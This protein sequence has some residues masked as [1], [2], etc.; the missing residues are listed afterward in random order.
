MLSSVIIRHL[1][2]LSKQD[3]PSTKKTTVLY[4]YLDHKDTNV[5][6]IPNLLGS[7]LRQLVQGCTV[8]P[9]SEPVRALFKKSKGELR[10]GLKD[11]VGLINQEITTNFE[12]VYLLVDALDELPEDNQWRLRRPLEDSLPDNVRLL[13]TSRAFDDIAHDKEIICDGDECTRDPQVG[14]DYYFHCQVCDKF[15]LCKSCRDKGSS[16]PFNHE[17][18]EPEFVTKEI[19]A[20]ND[21]I[22]R[23]VKW[24][25]DQ[26]RGLGTGKIGDERLGYHG[27]IGATRLGIFCEKFPELITKI[28][29]DVS[30]KAQGMYLLAKLHMDSLKLRPSAGAVLKALTNLSTEVGKIYGDILERIDEQSKIDVSLAKKVLYWIVLARRPLEVSELLQA[31]AVDPSTTEF[32]PLEQTELTIILRVTKGLVAADGERGAVRLVHR[33]AQEYFEHHWK[34]LFPDAPTKIA[35]TILS[36][37]NVKPLSAPCNINDEEVQVGS[38]L[39]EYPFFA[40]AS[41]YWGE[42]IQAVL[43]EPE[44]Q[45]AVMKFLKDPSKLAST[46]QAAWYVG[47][48]SQSSATWNVRGGVNGLHVCAYYGLDTILTALL[49]DT[50]DLSLDSQDRELGQTPLMYACRRGHPTTVSTLIQNGADVNVRSKTGSTAVFESIQG[51]NTDVLDILLTTVPL[52]S[53][54]DVNAVNPGDYNRTVLMLAA[55]R[56][57]E[58][59]I[60]HLMQQPGILIN[61]QDTRGYTALALAASKKR[62]T[63]VERLLK[64]KEIDIDVVNENGATPLM[65][66]AEYGS[67]E[68][69]TQLLKRNPDLYLKDYDGNTAIWLAITHGRTS[70]VRSMLDHGIDIYGKNNSGRT[71]LHNACVSPDLEPEVVR[72][73]FEKGADLNARGKNGETPL[74]DASRLGNLAIAEMLI[75][76]GANHSTEDSSDRTPLIVAWQHGEID[77][78]K[79]LQ[80]HS[81]IP[82]KLPEEASLP[83]WSLAKLGYADLAQK[84]IKTKSSNLYSKDPDT[85]YTALHWSIDCDRFIILELLLDS[86]MPPNDI[87]D[88][89]RTPLHLAAELGD[90]EATE[91]LLKANPSLEVKNQ[92]SATALSVAQSNQKY[93]VATLLLEAGASIEHGHDDE[94]QPTFFA[95]L[96]LGKLHAVQV[97]LQRGADTH[98]KNDQ[99]QT[100]MQVAKRSGSQELVDL[101]KQ[102]QSDPLKSSVPVPASSSGAA[103]RA[104]DK[105]PAS[106]SVRSASTPSLPSPPTSSPPP[107]GLQSAKSSMVVRTKEARSPILA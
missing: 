39:E 46:I 10:P 73:L 107:V 78:V 56:G 25:L 72:L 47:S 97:L 91:R 99:N 102:L 64:S 43:E 53:S 17:F 98:V 51:S 75:Q 13:I 33:T 52:G 94:I 62:A 96:Q 12:R 79:L 38:R 41:T 30:E 9:L 57:F 29:K 93:Y 32:D 24:D 45:T 27:K 77:V 16:C 95:A 58:N 5:Q 76:L 55:F 19:K 6:T 65:I 103:D 87:D 49:N 22:E 74:H 70:V 61:L 88:H 21:E 48:K 3:P 37:L 59:A 54:L 2:K 1:E 18:K 86:G 23:F 101:L 80:Q 14:L 106:V 60:D 90:Y 20:P 7:L 50:T 67:E 92:W 105:T 28:P 66:A 83:L 81:S 71:L 40:Y 34:E 84:A 68:I 82:Q 8:E 85:Q 42:H 100:V 104:T 36:Y 26:Q 4:L 44:V 31:L 11:L 63:I 15:D 89:G 69:V 35:I